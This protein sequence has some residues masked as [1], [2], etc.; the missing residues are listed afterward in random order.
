MAAR[1][2]APKKYNALPTV[3]IRINP[4]HPQAGKIIAAAK[5]IKKGGTVVFPTETVYGLGA[6]ALNSNS[7]T[8]IFKAKRRPSDN[9][10]I[11]H[12][13]NMGQLHEIAKV[14]KKDEAKIKRMW[15]GPITFL[16]YKKNIIPDNVTAGSR[17]V[18]VRMP[19]H[20]IALALIK[21]SN[22]PIAAPS[23]NLST[24]PSPTNA[25][26][27][28]QDLEGRVD[29][30]IDGKDAFFGIEST[31]VDMTSKTPRVL[32]LGAFSPNDLSKYLG[33]I[34][35]PSA[36]TKIPNGTIVPGMKYRH[37]S[38]STKMVL[39]NSRMLPGAVRALSRDKKVC[40]ICTLESSKRIK[41]VARK[42]V[43]GPKSDLFAIARNL[44]G[45]FRK[46]DKMHVDIC[47]LEEI[48]GEGIGLAIANRSTKACGNMRFDDI[49]T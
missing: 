28:L 31:I 29:M 7:A 47:L 42:I 5:I 1:N 17:K 20:P 41:G 9:P 22:V 40:V 23:A 6:N 18:A 37:Y 30:I 14:G 46:M 2:I 35:V 10:L 33:K 21:E 3:R 43:L 25:R 19:A 16:F 34:K 8:K 45:S 26:H 12:I 15:P 39:V 27:A 24:K 44:F 13:A 4:L 11:V 48:K 36:K 32:R 38:P 49:A